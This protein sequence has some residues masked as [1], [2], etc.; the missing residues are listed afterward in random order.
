LRSLSTTKRMV[1]CGLLVGLGVVLSG[2]LE[3]P[4]N[5][6]GL[7][8]ISLSLGS[9]PV[10]LA[11][12]YFGPLYGA[13]VGGLW[14]L[15]QALLFP[16]G[17]YNPLFTL[18]AVMIGLIPGLF[19]TKGE[20][21][22]FLRILLAAACGHFVGSI[23]MNSLWLII[24]YGMPLEAAAI[25]ALKGVVFIPVYAFSVYLLAGALDRAFPR[26]A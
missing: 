19:F 17:G 18:S 22:T 5:F 24:S 21:P 26:Q 4:I 23:V 13:M 14:D 20:K 1:F 2:P 3:I 25:R 8:A 12:V 11:A 10:I 6:F 15:L 16:M 9:V 7:Y